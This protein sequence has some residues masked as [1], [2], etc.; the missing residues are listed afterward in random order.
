SEVGYN[1]QPLELAAAFGLE[2]L[3]RLEGFIK[4]R[5][6]NFKELVE[7]FKDSVFT[8]PKQREDA[9]WLAFPLIVKGRYKV[10]EFLEKHGIQTRPVMAGNIL[11]QPGFSKL[12][13][14]YPEADN[15]MKNALLIGCHQ[16]LTRKQMDYLKSV[17]KNV[18]GELR[19]ILPE[20]SK[21]RWAKKTDFYT[22]FLVFAKHHSA[23]PLAADARVKA[24]QTLV[25]FGEQVNR[26]VKADDKL[27]K[28]LPHR[29]LD[30]GAGIRASTDLGSRKRRFEALEAE[31]D[32][33]LKSD[34]NN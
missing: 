3:K 23:L 15:V 1:F 7:F 12:K 14:E 16:G 17:F 8:I 21:M 13:G 31:L 18:L 4:L 25:K 24:K 9:V 22:L 26:F 27:K 30:Y 2:Q 20:I 5:K 19:Q 10:V 28:D 32:D 33:V 29:V 11:K 6:K 34:S